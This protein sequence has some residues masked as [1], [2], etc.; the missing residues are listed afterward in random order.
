MNAITKARME[1][2]RREAAQA[3]DQIMVGICERALAGEPT[4][5]LEEREAYL[6]FA[7]SL[8]AAVD[9]EQYCLSIDRSLLPDV[10]LRT[11]DDDSA[12]VDGFYLWLM[13]QLEQFRGPS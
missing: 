10:A 1:T 5:Y 11:L 7:G 13:D 4:G 2:L 8:T 9:F 6:R 3:G 12:E